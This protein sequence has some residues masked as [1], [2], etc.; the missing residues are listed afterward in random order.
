MNFFK[1]ARY[2]YFVLQTAKLYTARAN[3]MIAM[4]AKM[5]CALDSILRKVETQQVEVVVLESTCTMLP[6]ENT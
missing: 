3:T 6:V 1:T 2:V 5:N 4:T